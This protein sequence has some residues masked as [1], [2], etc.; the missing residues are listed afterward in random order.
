M[1]PVVL[2]LCGLLVGI[3]LGIL[4]M[5]GLQRLHTQSAVDEALAE[6]P[7]EAVVPEGVGQV[8]D[9]LSSLAIVVGPHDEVLRSSESA[10]RLGLVRGSRV[11][12]DQLLAIVRD[13]RR[14]DEVR[15][16]DLDLPRGRGDQTI[17]LSVRVATLEPNLVFVLADDRTAERRIEDIR[18]DFVANVSHELKTPIGAVALLSEAVLEAAEDPDGVRRFAGRMAVESQRLSDLVVQLIELSRLQAH[19]PMLQAGRVGIDDVFADAVDRSQVDADAKGVQ[20]RVAGD[21]GCEV[22]GNRPQLVTAVT[23]L[24]Q[25]AVIYSDPDAKVV[26]AARHRQDG[27]DGYVEI[28][29][30]DN[31][32][33]IATSDLNRIFERFYRVDYAR[34]R[35]NGGTGLGLSIVK[36]IAAAHGGSIDVWSRPGEGST[37]SIRLPDA[38]T[39]DTTTD[40]GA[41]TT[42]GPDGAGPPIALAN[43]ASGVRPPT[44][45]HEEGAIMNNQAVTS[46][47]VNRQAVNNRR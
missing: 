33:G 28:T 11:V 29:V 17:H 3:G 8:L 18:R 7:R 1:L 21:R 4:I 5:V 22:L 9:V 14:E 47:A 45:G 43:P 23:N 42:S 24:V 19:D 44:D 36:H 16:L 41:T 20:L 25:N 35:A 46:Q 6:P 39:G 13:V 37:F 2:A 38:G 15:V 40:T 34:S 30:S 31:G 26:V 27:D 12:P 10:V 32:I